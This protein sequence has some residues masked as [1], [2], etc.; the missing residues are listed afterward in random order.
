MPAYGAGARVRGALERGE[1]WS[2]AGRTLDRGGACSRGSVPSNE[3][4]PVRGKRTSSN[5][6]DPARGRRAS[7][8]EAKPAWGDLQEG[9]LG[10][11]LRSLRHGPYPAWLGK[12]CLALLRV[13]SG[14]FPVV[15]GT[16]WAVPDS[17]SVRLSHSTT[18]ES[19]TMGVN[20][21][22]KTGYQSPINLSRLELREQLV[23]HK[24]VVL[25]RLKNGFDL[26]LSHYTIKRV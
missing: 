13:L 1:A 12:V 14:D 19:K 11:S 3:A 5:G 8:S 20:R 10:G 23:H 7:S 18:N 22:L 26:Y 15:K 16:P 25:L 4:E 6:T 24:S 9:R 21:A 17:V 2:R